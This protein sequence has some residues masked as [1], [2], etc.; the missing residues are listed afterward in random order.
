M[1]DQRN[2]VRAWYTV[3]PIAG[4]PTLTNTLKNWNTTLA[5]NN[6]WGIPESNASVN[7][8]FGITGLV[9][10]VYSS[11]NLDKNN[12]GQNEQYFSYTP[13]FT[14]KKVNRDTYAAVHTCYSAGL[15]C[16]AFVQRC[17]SYNGTTYDDYDTNYGDDA[18]NRIPEIRNTWSTTY[19]AANRRLEGEGLRTC[20]WLVEETECIVPGDILYV[21]GYNQSGSRWWH[22]G[23][24]NKILI[25]EER[26]IYPRNVWII[27][28][29][30]VYMKVMNSRSWEIISRI[31][32]VTLCEIRRLKSY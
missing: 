4:N 6:T 31:G 18:M 7:Y 20:S 8:R 13:G 32:G 29:A 30:G 11:L 12:D 28:S 3:N 5:P 23:I 21:T 16:S 10:F 26:L 27:E 15:D 22:F 14:S 9:N 24:V 2:A 17:A 25:S 19:P 1:I